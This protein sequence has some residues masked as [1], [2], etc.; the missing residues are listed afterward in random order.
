VTRE[1]SALRPVGLLL[2]IGGV[3]L[4]GLLAVGSTGASKL[5]VPSPDDTAGEMLHALLA[6]RESAAHRALSRELR[7]QVPPERL[8]QLAPEVAERLGAVSRL[9][10]ETVAEQDDRATV[11]ATLRVGAGEERTLELSLVKEEGFWRVASLEPLRALA[12]RS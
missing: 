11:R 2:L 4:V 3:F 8:E 7:A 12:P 6:H 5:L 9:T 10:T 1:L